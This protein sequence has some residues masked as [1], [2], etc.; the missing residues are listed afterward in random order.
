M[1][2]LTTEN[3][4]DFLVKYYKIL[5]VIT[6]VD[7]WK[8]VRKYKVGTNF[9]RDFEHAAFGIITLKEEDGTLEIVSQAQQPLQ[10][11]LTSPKTKKPSMASLY[12]GM[13]DDSGDKLVRGSV[14]KTLESYLGKGEEYELISDDA[15]D[16][17]GYGNTVAGYYYEADCRDISL[18][19]YED[20]SWVITSD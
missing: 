9:H 8:R 20:G 18:L 19:V 2:K 17:D 10:E 16:D 14:E 6:K 12:E 5:N 4:K 13:C 15:N 3:C 7:G 1:T 11:K